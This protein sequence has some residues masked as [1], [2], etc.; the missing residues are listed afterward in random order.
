MALIEK[1]RSYIFGFCLLDISAFFLQSIH[2]CQTQ[3]KTTVYI[4]SNI[5][6]IFAFIKIYFFL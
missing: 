4:Y 5:L 6:F 2:A 1:N 3:N